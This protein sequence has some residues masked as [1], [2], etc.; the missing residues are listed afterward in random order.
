MRT[1]M[2]DECIQRSCENPLSPSLRPGYVAVQR[3]RP[4]EMLVQPLGVTLP[5]R[6]AGRSRVRKVAAGREHTLAL[7]DDGDVFSLGE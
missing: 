6:D 3:G 7:T 2:R 5:V 4:L 1:Y